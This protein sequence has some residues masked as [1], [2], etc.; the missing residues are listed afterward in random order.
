MQSQCTTVEKFCVCCRS[1][2]SHTDFHRNKARSDG[3]HAHCKPCRC[4]QERVRRAENPDKCRELDRLRYPA[5]AETSK[6]RSR[7]WYYANKQQYQAQRAIWRSKNKSVISLKAKLF[8]LQHIESIRK[9][10]SQRWSNNPVRRERH[11]VVNSRRHAAKKNADGT[12]TYNDWATLCKRY[13]NKCLCCGKVGKMT[14][15]HIV[16]LVHG[17]PHSMSNIQPLCKSCNSSKNDKTIDY[18][19]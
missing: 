18:R 2:K 9:Y 15:D 13:G 12:F 11:K 10:D 3:F 19:Y 4:E 5:R 17:G 16:P 14:I 8:R 1:W 6:Q 7:N